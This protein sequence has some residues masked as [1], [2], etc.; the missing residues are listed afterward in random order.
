[1]K[2]LTRQEEHILLAVYHLKEEAYLV[3]IREQVKK[4][5]GKLYSVGTIYAPLSRLKVKGCLESYMGE[6]NPARGGKAIQYYR[7]TEEGYKV[8][9]DV[10]KVQEEMWK[11]FTVPVFNEKG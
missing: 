5:T 9:Q 8:L 3:P 4:Y 11:G 7:L 6:P 10:K 2:T 1:M